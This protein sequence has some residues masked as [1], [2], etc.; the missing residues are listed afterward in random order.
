MTSPALENVPDSAKRTDKLTV[1]SWAMW[2]W[3][4]AAFNAVLVPFVCGVCRPDSVG[5]RLEHWRPP[6]RWRSVAMTVAGRVIFAVAPIMGRRSDTRGPRRRSLAFRSFI[7]FV[8]M[9]ALYFIRNDAPVYF[10]VGL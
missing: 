2:D 7:T 6:A 3:R 5:V 8:L 4:S 9:A 10:W 1:F